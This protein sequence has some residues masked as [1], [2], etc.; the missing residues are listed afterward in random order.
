MKRLVSFIA[1]VV[2]AATATTASAQ[3]INIPQNLVDVRGQAS[4]TVQPD[5]FTLSISIRELE[6]RDKQSLHEQEQKIISAL[7]KVG[8]DAKS[9]LKLQNN[10]ST[11][12]RRSTAAEVRS[13][14]LTVMGSETLNKAFAALDALNLWEVKLSEAECTK[15]SDIRRELRKEAMR[16]AQQRAKDLAEA[17]DQNI[18]ECIYITD[19]SYSDDVRFHIQ[20]ESR[21]F[22][23]REDAAV[24]EYR[25]SIVEYTSQTIS[26]RVSAVFRLLK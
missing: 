12:Q 20:P 15:L 1:L 5:K 19:E 11:N 26:H 16:N 3:S 18:G 21:I 2:I 6:N 8:I 7:T 13:Y 9:A 23:A 24:D 14:T 22:S 4:C 25:P 10:Y 17:I